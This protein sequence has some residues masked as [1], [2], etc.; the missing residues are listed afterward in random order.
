MWCHMA[1]GQDSSSWRDLLFWSQEVV[2]IC[3]FK[4]QAIWLLLPQDFSMAYLTTV[5]PNTN[6]MV[7]YYHSFLLC[8]SIPT[9]GQIWKKSKVP[10][11][12]SEFIFHNACI[13]CYALSLKIA[14]CIYMLTIHIYIQIYSHSSYKYLFLS[15]CLLVTICFQ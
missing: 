12:F 3:Y 2:L 7:S 6:Q 5:K 14:I 13:F 10:V 9:K 4:G 8:P 11:D 1:Q 15:I